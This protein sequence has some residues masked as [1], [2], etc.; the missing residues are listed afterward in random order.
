VIIRSAKFFK[1]AESENR[2]SLPAVGVL[3]GVMIGKPAWMDYGQ[4]SQA[5]LHV[6]KR[7]WLGYLL[8]P[9]LYIVA[10]LLCA[11]LAIDA[12][13]LLHAL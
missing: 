7:D 5:S 10:A 8:D 11:V 2:F 1:F 3:G 6:L 12:F 4:S 9:V 13:V